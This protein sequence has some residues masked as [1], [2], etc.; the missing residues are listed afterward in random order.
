MFN[1]VAT[2]VCT[3][4]NNADDAN[5]NDDALSMIA[6]KARFHCAWAGAFSGA[7]Y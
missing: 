1:P 7:G 6:R 5:D 3:D 4:D 2:R